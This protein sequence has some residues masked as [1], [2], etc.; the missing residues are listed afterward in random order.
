MAGTILTPV[1]IW[2]DFTIKATPTA[3]V[4][5]QSKSGNLCVTELYIK[6]RT[7]KDGSVD[8]FAKLVKGK[9]VESA[10]AILMLGDFNRSCK[11]E[12]EDLARKGYIVLAVDVAGKGEGKDHF[13]HYPNSLYHAN[14]NNVKDNL[15]KIEGN[16]DHTCW[17]EWT[18]VMRY[19]LAYLK[20]LDGV[21]KV[22][23]F[24]IG[25]ACTVMWQVASTDDLDCACFALNAGWNG[26]RGM[27][28]FGGGVEPHFSNDLYKFIAGV[29]PQSYATH[30]RCPVLMLSPTNSD[31][32]DVD[33]AYDTVSRIGEEYYR[34]VHYSVGHFNSISGGG[35]NDALIFFESALK[36]KGK[37]SLPK[38]VDI[39][40]D[41]IDGALN[42]QVLPDK[43]ELVSVSVY[44]S[45]QTARPAL[46]AWRKIGEPKSVTK[47][48]E[49]IF[50][51]EPYPESGMVTLFAKAKYSSGF[52]ICSKI[53]SK[54]FTVEEINVGYKDNIIYSSRLPFA[55]SIFVL[56]CDNCNDCEQVFVSDKRAVKVKKG[57]GGIE[58]VCRECGLTTFKVNSKKDKPKQ[59][60]ILMFDA[61]AKTDCKLTVKLISDY[62]GSPLEY[63]A[64][65]KLFGGN[66]WHNFKLSRNKFKTIEGMPLKSYDKINA[67]SFVSDDGEFLLNNA[68]WV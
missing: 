50:E 67:I 1:A 59:D 47:K 29:E 26:Y 36:K 45:E 32:F 2:R 22:G 61:N 55:Q 19:A 56:P 9:A 42:I 13:T 68:L 46:R 51:F 58:G 35:Y 23:G 60:A 30:V 49:R 24:S 40:C 53:I 34:A 31:N 7:V 54:K 57:A 12:Q 63:L 52:S 5:S 64:T 43:K 21:T 28:K 27:Y 15:Y 39:K 6:G 48:G 66:V 37:L 14:Y 4:I 16:I 41:I 3:E 20:S 10:P 25:E 11:A 33:R 65:V 62:F 18:A 38:E 8:V 17:Y 44:I